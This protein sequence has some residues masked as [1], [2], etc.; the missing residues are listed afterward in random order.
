MS[1]NSVIGA[2]HHITPIRTYAINVTALIILMILT[3][4]A[5]RLQLD[6]TMLSNAI[7]LTIAVAK[8]LLIIF[9]FMGLRWA[10]TLCRVFCVSS[11]F[12]L[13][14]MYGIL[15]DYASRS[16]DTVIGF[17]ADAG[18]ALR[19]GDARLAAP[20][21]GDHAQEIAPGKVGGE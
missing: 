16:A 14:L 4:V 2:Q 5:S 19:E 12:F 1:T 21:P 9:I 11:F 3:V 8:G 6:N 20:T 18:S 15:L 10:S 13:A 17:H 7:A